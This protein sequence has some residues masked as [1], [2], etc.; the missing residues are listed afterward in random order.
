MPGRTGGA[1]R[2]EMG[3]FPRAQSGVGRQQVAQVPAGISG[4]IENGVRHK[5]PHPKGLKA[6]GPVAL[7]IDP[8]ALPKRLP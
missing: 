6:Q 4:V 3:H 1:V 7:V 8:R 5:R 2:I